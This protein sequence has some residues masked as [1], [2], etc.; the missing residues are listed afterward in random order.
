MNENLY[1][2]LKSLI[3]ETAG[4]NEIM[5][6]I[7]GKYR[8]NI[9]YAGDDNIAAGKRHIEVYAFGMTKSGNPVIRAFQLFGDTKTIIPQWKLFRLDRITKWE[10]TNMKFHTPISNR[11]SNIPPFNPNGDGSMSTVYKIAQF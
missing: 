1:N 2:K 4:R 7:D 5:D 9:H 6:A 11:G 3:L 8:V 10:P